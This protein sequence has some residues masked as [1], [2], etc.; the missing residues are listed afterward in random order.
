MTFAPDTVWALEAAVFLEN[1]AGEPDGLTTVEDLTDF[2]ARFTYSGSYAGSSAEL[3]EVRA[4]RGPFRTLLTSDRDSAVTIVNE[5]LRDAGAVPQLVRH[6][7]WDWHVHAVADETPL[8][9]RIRIETAMAM[10]D[11]IR[12]DEMSRLALCADETCSGV[13]L[14]LTRNRSRRFCSTTC[15]NRVAQAA[16]RARTRLTA[17]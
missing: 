11:V 1:T 17:H 15:G 3:E 6:D 16:H 10:L 8:A 5:W 12:A 2:V 7:G 14:D 4:L 9:L 13:V